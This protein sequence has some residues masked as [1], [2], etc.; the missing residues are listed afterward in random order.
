MHFGSSLQGRAA[1]SHDARV[2]EV[3]LYE[4]LELRHAFGQGLGSV[5]PQTVPREAH[6]LQH[7][8]V[9]V[10]EDG[11]DLRG[12]ELS[13]VKPQLLQVVEGTGLKGSRDSLGRRFADRGVHQR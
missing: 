4:M 1:L 13:L 6:N 7:G 5:G 8:V 11:R 12:G 9:G 10:L 2:P 3:H